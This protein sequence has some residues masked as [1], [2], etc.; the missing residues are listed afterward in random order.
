[1]SVLLR[2]HIIKRHHVRTTRFSTNTCLETRFLRI[3]QEILQTNRTLWSLTYVC[4]Y[5][6]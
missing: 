4:H 1:M 3:F 6:N 5:Y 2:I